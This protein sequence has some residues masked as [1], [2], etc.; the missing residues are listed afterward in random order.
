[1]KKATK[2]IS[3]A[4]LFLVPVFPLLVTNSLF[5]PFITGKALYFRLLVEIAFAGWIILAFLDARYRP[6]L[7]AITVG[8]TIFALVALVADLL[9]VN[10]IR[11]LWSNFER[12]EGWITII[13]LWAFFVVATAMFGVDDLAVKNLGDGRRMVEVIGVENSKRWWHRWF[14]VSLAVAFVVGI[15]GVCQLFGW[16]AIHQGS[17]RIDASLGNAI[18]M[19][20]YMLFHAFLA[21]YFFFVEMQKGQSASKF[22]FWLY[23]LFAIFAAFLLF[24][25]ATRGTILGLTGGIMLAL[26]VYAVFGKNETKKSRWIA[27]SVIGVIVL[28][29]VVFW[30]NRDAT[31]VK[32]NEVLNRLASISLK[33]TQTQ[34]RA[35]VWPMALTGWTERPILGWGQENFN[36]IFNANYN[37]LMW[38]HEQ[39]FDRAHNIY[40]DWL[41]NAGLVGILAYLA[42]YVLLFRGIWQSAL[43]FKNKCAMTGLVAGYMVHNVFVFDNLASYVLFFAVL[44][45]VATQNTGIPK[46]ASRS[47]GGSII[48]GSR[49]A[50]AEIVEYVVAPVSIVALIL[51]VFFFEA[52]P[53]QANMRLIDALGSCTGRTP[54]VTVFQKVFAIDAYVA[55]QE[56][57]EQSLSCAASVIGRQ[58]IPG[59]TKQAFAELALNDIQAQIKATPKD[60]RMY[61]LGGSFMNNIGDYAGALSLLEKAH[62]LSP[63]KQSISFE[64]ANSYLNN[65]QYAEAAALL[66]ETYKL[67]P[68]NDNAK[69]AYVTGLVLVGREAEARKIFAGEPA[70]FGTGQIAS[71]FVVRKEYQ[72]AIAI[73]KNLIAADPSNIDLQTKLAQVQYSAGMKS[74]AIATMRGIEKDHPEYKDQ[75]EAAI[76]SIE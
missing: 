35:Y 12:M 53:L 69:S 11:S 41:V 64:L 22:K 54:D 1:M 61:V 55:N 32:D 13:H 33:E 28:I 43:S 67:D 31:F 75:I 8:V 14:N 21:A 58:D 34:A 36:Y 30:L 38:R 63:E 7:N 47:G 44:G 45:F 37:P 26:F 17:T 50:R 16:A 70:L 27:G 15:Y 40:L 4:A 57:R 6:R 46:G 65:G 10:P 59:T 56:A 19:A 76:K 48:G 2:F 60:A 68:T 74:A 49:E 29:G 51:I 25:T 62:A 72:K 18:Y 5:F 23:G 20:V 9:G 42:L 24:E 66:E 71:V 39:W 3:L 73:Y 52:R